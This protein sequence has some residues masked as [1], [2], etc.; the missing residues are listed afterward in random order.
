MP[1]E[2]DPRLVSTNALVALSGAAPEMLRWLA[3]HRPDIT[4]AS[5]PGKAGRGVQIGFDPRWAEGFAACV[6]AGL[7][8]VVAASLALRATP[9]PG[10]GVHIAPPAE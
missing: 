7:P 8:P 5:R 1:P 4:P 3:Y 6:R 2:A 9:V 10:G